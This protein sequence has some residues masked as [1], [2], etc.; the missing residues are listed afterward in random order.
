[1]DDKK[2]KPETEL[3]RAPF[4]SGFI[5]PGI[6]EA[7]KAEEIA[8]A[9][10]C[11]GLWPDHVGKAG[12]AVKVSGSVVRVD[13]VPNDRTGLGGFFL[14]HGRDR[15]RLELGAMLAGQAWMQKQGS[16]MAEFFRQHANAIKR[17]MQPLRES[18][19]AAQLATYYSLSAV[20][21]GHAYSALLDKAPDILKGKKARNDP[22][23]CADLAA[24]A[25][26]HG[27]ELHKRLDVKP[28]TPAPEI[29]NKILA[30]D[31]R[32][33]CYL[34][35]IG[36]RG[37]KGA[38]HV[39]KKAAERMKKYDDKR[40]RPGDLWA[41]WVDFSGE[42]KVPPYLEILST[43]VLHDVV[44]RQSVKLIS[45]VEASGP[46]EGYAALPKVT[47]GIS[48]AFG[49]TAVKV[50]GEQYAQTP[51]VTETMLLPPS[52]IL[53]QERQRTRPHQ[54]VMPLATKNDYGEPLP[55]AIADAT[56]YGAI[57][58]A[59]GKLAICAL[60]SEGVRYGGLIES[61]ALE[62]AKY[63]NPKA[64]RIQRRELE[65]VGS[66]FIMIDGL[67]IYLPAGTKVR[68]FGA[69]I[70]DSV[71]KI[72][73]G[74]K[75]AIGLNPT[76]RNLAVEIP[77]GEGNP[78]AGWFLLNL[79]GTMRL[80]NKQPSL[81]R[82]YVRAAAGWNAAYTGNH[83]TFDKAHLKFIPIDEWAVMTNVFKPGVAE[84]LQATGQDRRDRRTRRVKLSED[85]RR[86]LSDWDA[87]EAEGLTVN[88][89]VGKGYRLLPP[90][91]YH[92]AKRAI[93]ARN[94]QRKLIK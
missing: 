62:F 26:R 79:S 37:I 84:Y 39:R 78:Y 73:K 16:L 31:E 61:T 19:E 45:I 28:G 25:S 57:S 27:Q 15:A 46:A 48:W 32:F 85:R 92:E 66:G 29:E 69:L 4:Q 44:R 88:E 82:H 67:F 23:M 35:D 75:L 56:L 71:D 33:A 3:P 24:A 6:T 49:G 64:K 74:M 76:F 22:H 90:E 42:T 47:A 30:I 14:K 21:E 70:P 72:T 80:P 93:Q 7:E 53:L 94:L 60:A 12:G 10:A 52:W 59:G 87:L 41:L 9:G 1:M 91:T 40:S 65:D 18:H 34:K 89:K 11:H 17:L 77:R 81:L 36:D 83:G 50:D 63:I 2:Q 55:V 54:T 43:V 68:P 38:A 5:C 13:H 86:V 51:K 20:S 8:F 58:P